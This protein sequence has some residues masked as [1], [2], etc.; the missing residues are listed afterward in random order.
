MYVPRALTREAL[1]LIRW[2]S[3]RRPGATETLGLQLANIPITLKTRGVKGPG[4][5]NV[6]LRTGF[7]AAGRRMWW[8]ALVPACRTASAGPRRDDRSP[9]RGLE[10]GAPVEKL[11]I[12]LLGKTLRMSPFRRSTGELLL[13]SP[14]SISLLSGLP[15]ASLSQS[16]QS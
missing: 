8:E 6:S 11:L 4:H 2:G 15:R 3:S 1:S 9:A 13:T 14:T 10:G 7:G 16:N 12:L 5:R